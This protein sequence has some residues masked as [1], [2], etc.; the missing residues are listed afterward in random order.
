VPVVVTIIGKQI[1]SDNAIKNA[2]IQSEIFNAINYQAD[3]VQI[4]RIINY[5]RKRSI[6]PLLISSSRGY[7][8]SQNDAEVAQYV[9]T[10]QSRA[11][12]ILCAVKERVEEKNI[13]TAY[14]QPLYYKPQQ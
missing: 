1:G 5:I 9:A 7:F 6:V 13:I 10:L 14:M 2:D 8:V 12:E 4:R 11:N 3:A